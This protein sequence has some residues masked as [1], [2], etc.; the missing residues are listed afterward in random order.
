MDGRCEIKLGAAQTTRQSAGEQLEQAKGEPA[1]SLRQPADVCKLCREFQH[2]GTFVCHQ[3][4]VTSS[5]NAETISLFEIGV[6]HAHVRVGSTMC[7]CFD[8]V[9]S[10]QATIPARHVDGVDQHLLINLADI[11]HFRC[12]RQSSMFVFMEHHII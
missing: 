6:A 3:H 11:L 9:G 4:S 2:D 8:V 12:F 5:R 10:I 1:S 7:W